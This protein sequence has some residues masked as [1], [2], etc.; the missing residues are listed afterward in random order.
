MEKYTQILPEH[1]KKAL[2]Q[3]R[4]ATH[5]LPVNNCKHFMYLELID[6][7][8]YCDKC[9]IGDEIHVVYEC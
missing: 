6:I 5:K 2:S 1:F 7:D 3:F 9:L 4:I 8:T